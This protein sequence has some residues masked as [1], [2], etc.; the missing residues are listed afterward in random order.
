ML[1]EYYIYILI[2]MVFVLGFLG[3]FTVAYAFQWLWYNRPFRYH[4]LSDEFINEMNK[5]QDDIHRE[6]DF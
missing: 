5:M 6:E 2:S 1:V 4:K 3:L